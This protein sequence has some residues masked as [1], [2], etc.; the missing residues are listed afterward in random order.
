M[1][2]NESLPPPLLEIDPYDEEVSNEI[3]IEFLLQENI[4]TQLD[5][6]ICNVIDANLKNDNNYN[7]STISNKTNKCIL[8]LTSDEIS[9]RISKLPE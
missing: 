3:L 1:D 6:E 4:L 9:D 2:Q 7:D 8:K 5:V